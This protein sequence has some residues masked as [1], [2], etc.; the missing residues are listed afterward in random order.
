MSTRHVVALVS[1]FFYPRLGG[2]EMHIWSL[3][4]CLLRRGHK[5]IVVT[6]H[7]PGGREG[8]RC[9]TSG[10][11]VYYCPLVTLV[12]Q[13]S[14]PTFHAFLPLFR[15]ILIRERVTIV[16][17]HQATSTMTNECILYARTMGYAACYTDHSLFGFADAASIHINVVLR[18]TLA[19]IDHAICVSNT[20]R[21]NLVLRA[22]LRP[23]R[24]STV[25]NA[26]D[27]SKFM[28]D[29][30][31]RSPRGT[32]NIVIISRLVYRKGT[33]LLAQIIPVV[34]ERYHNAHF[35]VGGDG[36]KRL[37]LEEMREK[38]QLHDRVELL[39]SVPH[40]QVRSVLV[41]GHI[42]LNC[43]L[44]EVKSA[45]RRKVKYLSAAERRIARAVLLHRDH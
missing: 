11:K 8:V 14:L 16:H 15:N 24:I 6:H 9:M 39:G 26:V 28:P 33:D 17:G 2:V 29:P 21:E 38:Y 34:C 45:E 37:L 41:R 32:I 4:Q 40:A 42:F 30:S 18:F 27:A 35:I 7:Y 23:E 31:K 12:D 1:D 13:D 43:S 20:C 22:G 36:P 19:D 10:L 25:P 44:T 3:A 5:V